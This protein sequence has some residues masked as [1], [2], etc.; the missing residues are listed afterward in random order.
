MPFAFSGANG[1]NNKWGIEMNVAYNEV[2]VYGN[3][4]T[5]IKIALNPKFKT[6]LWQHIVLTREGIDA[7]AENETADIKYQLYIDGELAGESTVEGTI[8]DGDNSIYP[9]FGQFYITS[10]TNYMYD[11]GLA[12]AKMYDDVLSQDR[13]KAHYDAD[14]AK[15]QAFNDNMILDIDFETADE[16]AVIKMSDKYGVNSNY[17]WNNFSVTTEAAKNNDGNLVYADYSKDAPKPGNKYV[18]INTTNAACFNSENELTIETWVKAQFKN[19]GAIYMYHNNVWQADSYISNGNGYFEVQVKNGAVKIQ[20]SS[21]IMNYKDGEWMHLVLTRDFD[22]ISTGVYNA[23][24]DGELFG[25]ATHTSDS[26]LPS[27]NIFFGTNSAY[28]AGYNGGI[29]DIKVYKGIMSEAD[30]LKAYNSQKDRYLDFNEQHLIFDADFSGETVTDKAEIATAYWSK[31]LVYGEEANGTPYLTFDGR[32]QQYLGFGTADAQYAAIAPIAGNDEASVEFWLRTGDISE[33]Q[34]NIFALHRYG[35]TDSV[36][37]AYIKNGNLV[38]KS[39]FSNTASNEISLGGKDKWAHIVLTRKYDAQN[40][41]TYKTY[42]NGVLADTQIKTDVTPAEDLNGEKASYLMLGGN[43]YA[44]TDTT[45]TFTGDI[46]AIRFYDGIVS[47]EQ[48]A[49]TYARESEIFSNFEGEVTVDYVN[50]YDEEYEELEAIGDNETI[51]I[52]PAFSSSK[53]DDETV[54]VYVG[55]YKGNGELVKIQLSDIITVEAGADEYVPDDEISFTIPE[56]FS[57]ANGYVK[58]F[59]WTGDDYMTPTSS[60]EYVLNCL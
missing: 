8:N 38:H 3:N 14:K 46:G 43:Y 2:K 54:K 5:Q 53:K 51:I 22:G 25:T 40:G 56:T 33:K 59:V 45:N 50:F 12:M 49:A 16:T 57:D 15:Y 10:S 4:A 6:G 20:N 48:V 24:V 18:T 26:A 11:G 60:E 29:G 13:I 44:S 36:W 27:G 30:V 32:A 21:K 31:N 35:N 52:E 47:A 34:Q 17:S 19:T 1:G 9:S 42:V 39:K 23:Y 41:M 58:V 37:G 55:L 28:V 7:S